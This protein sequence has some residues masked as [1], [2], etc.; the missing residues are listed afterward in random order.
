MSK[1]GVCDECRIS[2]AIVEV[3]VSQN[4]YCD[5]L[6]L[7]DECRRRVAVESRVRLVA[8]LDPVA[9]EMPAR[10]EAAA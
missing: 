6:L 10:G 7:C 1:R 5:R 2:I 3:D 8:V 4:D 9:L